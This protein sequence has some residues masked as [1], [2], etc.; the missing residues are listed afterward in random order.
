MNNLYSTMENELSAIDETNSIQ[1]I[2]KAIRICH[3]YLDKLKKYIDE[4]DFTTIEEE[5]T[6]FKLI[7]PKFLSKLIFYTKWNSLQVRKIAFNSK[8]VIKY[9]EKECRKLN[10]FLKDNIDFYT[11][12]NSEKTHLDKEFFTRNK[13]DL[14]LS[15]E[16]FYFS[17]DHSFSTTHDYL[18]AQIMASEMLFKKLQ[19]EISK[20]MKNSNTISTP[21]KWTDKKV[22]LVELIYAIYSANSINRGNIEI[23]EIAEIFSEAF[24]EDFG[25]IYR[26]YAEIKNR[27]NPTRYLDFLKEK[28]LEKIDDELGN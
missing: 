3:E 24:N 22:D 10:R 17:L 26:I 27:K 5:I 11:Y 21:Y 14:M 20:L 2:L 16:P 9:Y 18:T 8:I 12:L 15:V 28:I 4:N 25:N 1:N 23:S 19:E 13:P 7:K 6:F